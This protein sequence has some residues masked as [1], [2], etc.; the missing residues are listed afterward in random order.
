M[1]RE[2]EFD[3]KR[4]TFRKFLSDLTEEELLKL[5]TDIHVRFDYLRSIEFFKLTG[6]T[7][8]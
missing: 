1:T 5:M 6:T 2:E 3:Y 4:Q 8:N 7:Q